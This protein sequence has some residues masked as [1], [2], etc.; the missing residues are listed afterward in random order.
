MMQ[1]LNL[2]F[3]EK[4]A[5]TT[6]VA[7]TYYVDTLATG[8]AMPSGVLAQFKC[9]VTTTFVGLTDF[10]VQLQ[11]AD[12][13]GFNTN[14][15]T[16]CQSS[17]VPLA[18]LVAQAST[19]G[20]AKPTYSPVIFMGPLPAGC[21]RYLRAYYIVNPGLKGGDASAGKITAEIILTGDKLIDGSLA[22]FIV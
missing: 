8:D 6:S 5:V 17:N 4:L 20:P 14:A 16:L 10:K 2:R 22:A 9:L 15:A 1:D 19:Y 3:D 7:S 11:T 21:R 12:D 18:Q 13:T